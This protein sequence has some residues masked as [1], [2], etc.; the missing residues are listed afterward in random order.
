MSEQQIQQILK[1]LDQQDAV[2]QSIRKDI[3]DLQ[4]QLQPIN[5]VFHNATGFGRITVS[6]LKSLALLGAGIGVIYAF[7]SW[8][9]Q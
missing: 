4:E 8:I 9:R 1:R 2:F 3:K 7:I 5:D 6:I